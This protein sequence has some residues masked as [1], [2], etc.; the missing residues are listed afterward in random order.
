MKCEH[1][2]MQ[3]NKYRL[4]QLVINTEILYCTKCGKVKDIIKEVKKIEK[5]HI[6]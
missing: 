2:Y 1:N 3:L 4:G 5:R 6:I